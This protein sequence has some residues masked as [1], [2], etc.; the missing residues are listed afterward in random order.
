MESRF[1]RDIE[2]FTRYASNLELHEITRFGDPAWGDPAGAAVRSFYLKNG[3]SR[4]HS[5]LLTFTPEGIAIQGNMTPTQPGTT[6]MIGVSLGWFANEV[7]APDYVASK[8]LTKR[9]V[10]SHAARHVRDLISDMLNPAIRGDD[11][12]SSDETKNMV[13]LRHLSDRL[14]S[15]DIDQRGMIDELDDLKYG[16][17]HEFGIDYDPTEVGC[18]FAIQQRFAHLYKAQIL[19]QL[20]R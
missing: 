20:N 12:L 9:F 1:Q 5:V 10:P 7:M 15:S 13:R 4:S 3:D 2:I 6:S 8:F 17:G 16:D 19:N 11:P 18:L 14:E